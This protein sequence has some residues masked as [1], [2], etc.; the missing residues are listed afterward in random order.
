[1]K[2]N[3]IWHNLPTTDWN[4]ATPLGNGRLG[5]MVFGGIAED[6]I[7]FN[8]ETVWSGWECDEYDSPDTAAHLEEM[9]QLIFEGRYAEAQSLSNRYMICR[10]Q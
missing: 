6:R 5:M 8:E 9:R 10:G 4:R 3:K 2:E 7:Q 1:M